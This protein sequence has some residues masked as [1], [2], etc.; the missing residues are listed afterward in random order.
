MSILDPEFFLGVVGTGH[1]KDPIRAV[2]WVDAVPIFVADQSNRSAT[3]D[4]FP[5]LQ[6]VHREYLL[7]HWDWFPDNGWP[8]DSW[9]LIPCQR[10]GAQAFE[11]CKNLRDGTPIR[12]QHDRLGDRRK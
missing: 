2:L 4:P 10:C 3:W 1:P 9:F 5:R 7:A 11:V 6:P 12:W 8:M